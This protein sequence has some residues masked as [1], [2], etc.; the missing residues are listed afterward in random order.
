MQTVYC[1]IFVLATKACVFSLFLYFFLGKFSNSEVQVFDT[2]SKTWLA[3]RS[4]FPVAGVWGGQAFTY[5]GTLLL[6][7]YQDSAIYEYNEANDVWSKRPGNIAS[8]FHQDQ[9]PKAVLVHETPV[10]C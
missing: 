5:M 2:A 10:G 4:P 9:M 8:E 3:E 1:C 6:V 7:C